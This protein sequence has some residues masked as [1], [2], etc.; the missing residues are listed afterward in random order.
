MNIELV[1]EVVVLPVV[2]LLSELVYHFLCGCTEVVYD[3]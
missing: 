2:Y 1:A 3:G